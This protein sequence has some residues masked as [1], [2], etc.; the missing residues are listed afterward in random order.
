MSES[1][2]VEF[3]SAAV[4]IA[5]GTS[6]VGLASA[7]KF[8]QAGVPRI[9][10][11]GRTE[12]RGR[13][14]VDAVKAVAPSCDVRF[15]SA[16]ANDANAVAK[17]VDEVL[18]AFGSVEIV[19]NSTVGSAAPQLLKNIPLD[20]LETILVEQTMGPLIMSR[21]FLP[22]M[23]ERRRGVILNIAS[24]AAKLATPG[25]TVIGA[26]MAAI[27]MFTRALAIEAKRDGIRVNALTP[28]L[29]GGTLTHKR[30]QQSPF[31]SKLFAKA[32]TMANLGVA[33]ADDL[34]DLALFLASPAAKK[35]T[36]Q[37]ISA[38]GGISAA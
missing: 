4:V 7:C 10:L 12:S 13:E 37:A 26:G 3:A 19:L 17:L 15:F 36:G 11:V 5:G 21:A 2:V 24:D 20:Q 38:N 22:Q 27:V 8:A 23:V 34:A 35:I 28:S 6:G 1:D 25:E 32:A 33:E 31:A 18:S 29:I 30:M 9:A 16:D 14:A